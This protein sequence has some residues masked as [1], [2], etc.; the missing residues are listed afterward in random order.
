MTKL[1]TCTRPV[2]IVKKNR[3]LGAALAVV[4]GIFAAGAVALFLFF[5]I[6]TAIVATL[7]FP[8]WIVPFLLT[9]FFTSPLW[10][11]V[12]VVAGAFLA[13]VGTF[14]LGL[15]VTSLPVR[16]KGALLTTKIKNSDVGKRVVYEKTD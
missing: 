10:V 2:D 16:R 6:P 13:F 9:A 8:F 7:T 5:A 15:G 3:K 11:P 12:L 14:V 4:A 1:L